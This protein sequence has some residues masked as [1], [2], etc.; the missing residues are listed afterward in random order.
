MATPP[1]KDTYQQHTAA[2]VL[3]RSAHHNDEREEKSRQKRS[4]GSGLT[5]RHYCKAMGSLKQQPGG[6]RRNKR[7]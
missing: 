2:G 4:G 7:N 1:A 3:Y 5:Y 6:R